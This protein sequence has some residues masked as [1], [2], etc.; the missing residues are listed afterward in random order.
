MITSICVF[1]GSSEG[2][3][4]GYVGAAEAL[5]REIARR[6]LKL[7]YGGGNVGTMGALA[8][9]TLDAGG[10]V[11]G[12]IPRKLYEIVDHV[13]LTELVVAEGMHERKAR[14]MEAADA[15]IALPGGIGTFE[16]LFEVWTW[17]QI[18]FH[19]KPLALLN[20]EGFYDP[21]LAFLAKVAEEG[22]LKPVHLSDLIVGV[23]PG[24]ILDRLDAAGPPSETKKPER[25]ERSRRE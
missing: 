6:G 23:D 22:F 7:V 25:H 17:R 20:V 8:C 19:A 15:F 21:L 4:P 14:M 1:C 10:K 18:G 13:E 12:V 24:L 2:K 16:E 3:G 5:G 9:A 11:L